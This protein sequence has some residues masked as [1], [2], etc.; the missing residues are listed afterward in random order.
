M[1]MQPVLT[2]PSDAWGCRVT[3]KAT[4]AWLAL[5]TSVFGVFSP[6]YMA[7]I[8]SVLFEQREVWATFMQEVI[9]KIKDCTP[10]FHSY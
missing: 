10:L 8:H 3:E 9:Y 2:Q 4:E 5:L 6:C 1:A 7:A